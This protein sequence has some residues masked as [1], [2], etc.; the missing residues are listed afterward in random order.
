MNLRGTIRPLGYWESAFVCVA[1]GVMSASWFGLVLA[2]F[3][4]FSLYRLAVCVFGSLAIGILALSIRRR[5]PRTS[6]PSSQQALDP[7]GNP[8]GITHA[9]KLDPTSMTNRAESIALVALIIVAAFLYGRPFE[10]ILGGLDSGSYVNAGVSIAREGS[11]FIKDTATVGFDQEQR[12]LLFGKAPKP[13]VDGNRF[14]GFYLL[15]LKNG[16]VEP[17]GFHLFPIWIAIL[18]SIGGLQLGLYATPLFGLLGVLSLY[19]LGRRLFGSPVGWLAAFFMS[20]SIDQVWFSKFPMAET[21]VQF[22]LLT[23]LYAFII[24]LRLRSRFFAVL[25]GVSFGLVH[26][27][28]IEVLL[29]PLALAL[30]LAVE[31]LRGSFLRQYWY[32]IATY[33][34]LS[35]QAGL[36]AVTVARAYTFDVF[37]DTVLNSLNS[38]LYMSPGLQSRL[39]WIGIVLVA[40]CLAAVLLPTG[41]ARVFSSGRRRALG[42]SVLRAFERTAPIAFALALAIAA[43]YGYYL[44][45]DLSAAGTGVSPAEKAYDINNSSSLVRLG[46]Y[47]SPLGLLLGF[48]GLARAVLRDLDRRLAIVLLVSLPTTLLFLFRNFV[49]PLHFWAGR[50]FVY[51]VI[52]MFFLFAAYALVGLRKSR[53]FSL[54]EDAAPVALGLALVFSLIPP[55]IPFLGHVEFGG[56]ER[57]LA[58]LADDLPKDAVVLFESSLDANRLATPLQYMFGR[59]TFLFA[60]ESL[61]DARFPSLLKKWQAENKKVLWASTTNDM[62]AL[63]QGYRLNHISTETIVLPEAELAEDRLPQKVESYVAVLDIFEFGHSEFD[64]E[65][66]AQEVDM[67]D[68]SRFLTGV[69]S[70]DKMPDMGLVR[71]T[72]R[73]G[74]IRLPEWDFRLPAELLIKVAGNRPA[75]LP[76]P[77]M[78]VLIN[79]EVLVEQELT[80]D[81]RVYRIPIGAGLIREGPP[82][83]ELVAGS[84]N[85]FAMGIGQDRRDLGVLVQS[86]RVRQ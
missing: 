86:I 83:L 34:L 37:H 65:P 80:K 53:R 39:P 61:G 69:Y 74:R 82:V 56:S 41:A 27:A 42:D 49:A 63:P 73:E 30:F 6:D 10:Y 25:A 62:P 8:S 19:F 13:W 66:V 77:R 1:V 29:L 58:H 4:V 47:I 17:H 85:P 68:D 76:V 54:G 26:L 55:N 75:Y 48:A 31:A 23:G 59:S 12:E 35:I 44:R 60:K 18:Y 57:Q 72:T 11:I 24:M 40:L 51:I 15:D 43:V 79:K 2:E 21:L 28:K 3:G 78:K 50:R 36:H 20:I 81:F 16:T 46:W 9:G 14:P 70:P 33:L 45:P 7:G 64:K 67:A 84:W 52:P 38:I 71:W 32:L 5:G 22:L